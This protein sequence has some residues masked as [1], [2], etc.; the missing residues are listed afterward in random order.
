MPI[1][2]ECS[3]IQTVNLS[4]AS[5]YSLNSQKIQKMIGKINVAYELSIQY[6]NVALHKANDYY[7]Y[8]C[9]KTYKEYFVKV[10][11]K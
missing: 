11:Y 7:A 10:G 5:N 4:K 1:N 3:T 6:S 8:S 9:V 2:F